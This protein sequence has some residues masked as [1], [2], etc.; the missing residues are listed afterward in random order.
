VSGATAVFGAFSISDP[1]SYV[2]GHLMRYNVPNLGTLDMHLAALSG[3]VLIALN[4]PNLTPVGR[5]TVV[6]KIRSD[7]DALLDRRLWLM[8]TSERPD[9]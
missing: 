2:Q 9:E 4:A 1:A 6:G 7:I 8:L 5:V 3:R